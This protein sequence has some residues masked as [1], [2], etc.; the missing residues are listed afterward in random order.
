MRDLIDL[1]SARGLK[2][3]KGIYGPTPKNGVVADIYSRLGFSSSPDSAFWYRSV[4]LATD[5][6][7]TYIRTR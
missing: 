2:L 6:L 1:A 7:A 4:G 5:D 3:I